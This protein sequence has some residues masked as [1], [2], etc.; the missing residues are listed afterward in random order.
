EY[1]RI[2]E[3]MDIPYT[4][5]ADASDIF[6]S[7]CDGEYKLYAGGTK[8]EDAAESINGKATIALQTHS[9]KNT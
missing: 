4:M 8:L 9:T 3:L 7:G 2:C 1:K 6:D 5:L